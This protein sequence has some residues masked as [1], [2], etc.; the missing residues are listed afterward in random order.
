MGG[1]VVRWLA[2]LPHKKVV[3]SIPTPGHSVWSLLVLPLLPIWGERVN[4]DI[5][6]MDTNDGIGVGSMLAGWDRFF[7]FSSSSTFMSVFAKTKC[8]FSLPNFLLHEST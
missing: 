1:T 3:G 8:I 6:D 5:D 2:L 7:G 4:S